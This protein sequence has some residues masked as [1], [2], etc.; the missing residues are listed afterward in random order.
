MRVRVGDADVVADPRMLEILFA[1][2]QSIQETSKQY[3]GQLNESI[4]LADYVLGKVDSVPRF[5]AYI[6]PTI[7]SVVGRFDESTSWFFQASPEVRKLR[8]LLGSS[9]AK[10]GA[11]T[12]SS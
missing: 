4:D 8:D 10:S 9:R 7:K 2:R 12:V 11:T 5:F 1:K 3:R 6:A